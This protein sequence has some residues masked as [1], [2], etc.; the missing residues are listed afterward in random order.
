M[1][2]SGCSLA[3]T[4][5]RHST[6]TRPVVRE[7]RV[8]SPHEPP[9]PP[10]C[11]KATSSA[12]PVHPSRAGAASPCPLPGPQDPAPHVAREQ[13]PCAVTQATFRLRVAAPRPPPVRTGSASVPTLPRHVEGVR[14]GV[15]A[16]PRRL[17]PDQLA[18]DTSEGR[19]GLGCNSEGKRRRDNRPW[20]MQGALREIKR[21]DSPAVSTGSCSSTLQTV[22]HASLSLSQYC[23]R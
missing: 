23:L 13:R 21:R 1:P 20:A 3:P 4:H 14:G 10:R 18:P 2:L 6:N 7:D 16:W 8:S 17:A 9:L 15:A 12:S 5:G 11:L 22:T 19:T